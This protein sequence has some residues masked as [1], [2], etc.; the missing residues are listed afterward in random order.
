LGKWKRR[1]RPET[2][3]CLKPWQVPG[4]W[5]ERDHGVEHLSTTVT[6]DSGTASNSCAMKTPELGQTIEDE[7]L[8]SSTPYAGGVEG[9]AGD[10]PSHGIPGSSPVA[11]IKTPTTA[12][13]MARTARSNQLVPLGEAK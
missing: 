12:T 7:D 4:S 9:F 2:P 8:G 3:D 10:L 6:D 1:L 5:A 13:T 11:D